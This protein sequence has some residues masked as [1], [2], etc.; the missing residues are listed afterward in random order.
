MNVWTIVVAAGQGDRFGGD[1][2][3]A[4]LSGRPVLTHSVTVASKVSD[5]VVV[6]TAASRQA[7]VTD[8]MRGFDPLP[9]VVPG[10]PTRSSSVRSGLAAVPKKATVV[11]VHDGARPLASV[12]LFRRV[13][14]GVADGADAVVPGVAV[15]DSLRKVCGGVLD[16]ETV[17]A[18]QTPQGFSARSLRDAHRS[19]G[20]VSDDATLVEAAGGRV[21]V[22]D[23][24]T[25]N[26]KITVPLD[27][28]VAEL[29]IGAV[30][31][32]AEGEAGFGG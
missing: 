32:G 9:K 24:E 12:D 23:G 13:V 21:V 10:G 3:V 2:Q 16:R 20:E 26:L 17:I 18:V 5:G 8:L 27:L 29:L 14:A 19:G 31:F 30:G 7:A 6:V 15:S 4:D 22:I 28:A 25:N 1:K 11:L